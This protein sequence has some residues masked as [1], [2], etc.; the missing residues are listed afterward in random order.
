M[1]SLVFLETIWLDVRYSL[2]AMR[3]NPVFTLTAVL[4]MAPGIGANTAMFTV[5]RGVL[6]RPLTYPA[7]QQLVSISIDEMS[8]SN[9]NGTLLPPR[10]EE[11]R[12]DA[13][14][15]SAITAYL[16]S[17]EDMSLSGAGGPEAVKVARVSANF[18]ATLGVQPVTGRGF[19]SKED[20]PG[21]PAVM[22]ISYRLWRRR[23]HSDPQIA[24]KSVVLNSLPYAVVG[25][26]P[27][28]FSFPFANT[29][30]WVAKPTESSVL[31]AR[32][33]PYLTPLKVFARLMPGTTKEQAHAEL[34]V[35]HRQ[36]LRAHPENMDSFAGLAI[37]VTSL[38][39]QLVANLR[40]TLWI[41]FGAVSLVLLIACANVAGLLLSRAV[42]RSREF[43]LRAAIGA[44]GARLVRQLL[45]EST[46]LAIVGGVF[47]SILA[48]WTLTAV[49]H[50][51]ALNL[52]GSAPVRVDGT[53]LVFTLGLSIATGIIFG[54]FPSLRASRRDLTNDLRE[55]GAAAGRLLAA[56]RSLG[57]STRG[58]LVVGQISL[59]MVLLIGAGLLMKSFCASGPLIRASS[60]QTS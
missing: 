51:A 12:K 56:P 34:D 28:G 13:Q 41:L 2:R 54:L 45:A 30:V 5:I 58:L 25:V 36:Y 52:P 31:P 48:I 9:R 26:L 39:V 24:G 35:L 10:V 8:Q 49:R 18:F 19:L 32:F 40:S 42:S 7:P 17:Q 20:T 15:F 38:Q 22:L 37:H 29:D 1:S 16:K 4:T 21:G 59:S 47:G 11:L 6:L 14:S 23:F 46:V 33:W 53:V 43:A 27:P 3:K 44:A 50:L 55:S 60:Q 57:V